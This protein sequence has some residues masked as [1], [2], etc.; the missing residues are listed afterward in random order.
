MKEF[1]K[2]LAAKLAMPAG[3]IFGIFITV[4]ILRLC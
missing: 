1:L 2:D 4:L 3:V